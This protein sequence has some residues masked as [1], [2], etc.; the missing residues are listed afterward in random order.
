MRN[1]I[2]ILFVFLVGCS[3]MKN[4][5][6]NYYLNDSPGKVH[7]LVELVVSQRNNKRINFNKVKAITIDIEKFMYNRLTDKDFQALHEC[8][9]VEY[10]LIKYPKGF[11]E[12]DYSLELSEAISGME[13][14]SQL[15]VKLDSADYIP[16]LFD[17]SNKIQKITIEGNF[18]KEASA[19]SFSQKSLKVLGVNC[20][21]NSFS[22]SGKD[23][24]ELL[25][26]SLNI[27]GKIGELDFSGLKKLEGLNLIIDGKI[28]ELDISGLKKL[29][30]LNFYNDEIEYLP[31]DFFELPDLQTL[32]VSVPKLKELNERIKNLKSLE[33]L[34]FSSYEI[35]ELPESLSKLEHLEWVSINTIGKVSLKPLTSLTKLKRLS[36]YGINLLEVI[37]QIL[38]MKKLKV[39]DFNLQPLLNKDLSPLG[40]LEKLKEIRFKTTYVEVDGDNYIPKDLPDST[41]NKV[42]HQ[43][44]QVL[45]EHF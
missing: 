21:T 44:K 20:S 11:L 37:D 17:I 8:H 4:I 19:N 15:H 18:I 22:F 31:N 2:Y 6:H 45:P 39:L 12:N 25:S 34:L 40:Q 16:N 14:L 36:I 5:H 28:E 27:N 1:F 23:Y 24:S 13:K 9:A 7:S 26:L 10:I 38:L 32:I 43:L 33:S 42:L 29:E 41:K 3:G 30:Y 35:I